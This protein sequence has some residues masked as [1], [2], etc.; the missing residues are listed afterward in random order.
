MWQPRGVRVGEIEYAKAGDHHIAYREYRGDG[1]ADHEIV[2]VNGNNFPM[3][4]LPDDPLALRALEG[5]SAFGRLVTF[6]RRGIGLSDPITDWDTPLREQWADDLAAVISASGCDRPTVFS[7]ETSAVARTC[8]VSHPELIGRLVL[9]N[10]GAPVTHDDSEWIP[11]FVEAMDQLRAGVRTAGLAGEASPGRAADPAFR[12]WVDAAGRAGASPRVAERMSAKGYADPPFD[13]S[14][15]DVPTLVITR[16]PP[17][18]AVPQEFFR[19]AAQQIPGAE[20]AE[21]GAGDFGVMGL[22]VDD[23]LAAV[24]RYLTGEVRL[25]APERELVVILFTDLVGSTRRAIAAGDAAWKEL[26]DHHDAVSRREVTRRGGEVVKTTGDGVLALL[27][28]ATG[29]IEA[30]RSVRLGLEDDDLEVRIGVHVGEVDRRADDVSGLAVNIT[31]RI[32]GVAG[33]GEILVSSLVRDIVDG[34]EC[35]SVGPRDLK[36]IDG[37]WELYAVA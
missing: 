5:L 25:P 18:F 29:A 12:G 20:H 31:A 7:W 1:L 34:A 36:D 23:V 35:T 15:V 16:S 33:A 17:S 19:R 24:S 26:L 3:E 21:L 8:S 11:V 37:S 6:D 14:T 10:P 9:F 13:N 22:G 28:S 27:P 2:M 30:A 32:M 4:S